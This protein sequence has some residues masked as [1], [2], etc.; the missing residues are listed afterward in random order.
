MLVGHAAGGRPGRPTGTARAARKPAGIEVQ[1]L[2][3]VGADPARRGQQG[4]HVGQDGQQGEVEPPGRS[5]PASTGRRRRRHDPAMLPVDPDVGSPVPSAGPPTT[6]LARAA[7]SSQDLDDRNP[8]TTTPP[9][10]PG[11]V[12]VIGAGP[13]GSRPPTSSAR[14]AT[15]APCSRAPTW[16]AG[17]ARRSCATAGGS[18]SAA[19]GSSP[20]SP[21]SRRSGTRSSPTRTSCSGPG[22]AASTT[23]ASST[24]TRCK[25]LN[26]LRNL[27]L[28]RGDALR[29][30]VPLGAGPA[31]EGPDH[32]RGLR[33][34]QLRLAALR[35]LLQDLQREG[36]GGAAVGDLRRLGRP[37][38]QGHVAVDRG[39]GAAAAPASP[40][41]GRRA[42][43]SPA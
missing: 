19:T 11:S 42:S 23:R 15:R 10:R 13:P 22:R 8:P 40:G 1:V 17:S 12:V 33:R 25:P 31:A 6:T 4:G 35:P 26:A 7:A 21:R 32:A 27:G 14:P 18:T 37:A 39:V 2:L 30:V 29:A 9:L 5:G 34:R 38:H 43:R 24:T 41:A 20:R 3:A 16:S 36:V 28:D